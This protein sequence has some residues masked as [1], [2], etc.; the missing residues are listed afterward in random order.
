M[1]APDIPED[2]HENPAS[3]ESFHTPTNPESTSNTSADTPENM[4]KSVN[5]TAATTDDTIDNDTTESLDQPSVNDLLPT[6]A[7]GMKTT[8]HGGFSANE[9]YD[10]LREGDFVVKEIPKGQKNNCY[11]IIDNSLNYERKKAN[12]FNRFCDDLGAWD[13]SKGASVKSYYILS[14][15]FRCV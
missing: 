12:K 9:I 3:D 8:P 11:T 1:T 2:I 13:T 6:V 15:N 7:S 14:Q 5:Q 4:D 10:M